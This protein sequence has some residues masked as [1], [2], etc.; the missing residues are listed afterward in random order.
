MWRRSVPDVLLP[1]VVLLVNLLATIFYIFVLKDKERLGKFFALPILLQKSF[2]VL[3]VG[4]LVVSPFVPQLKVDMSPVFTVP[5]GAVL[6][7]EGLL[8]IPFSF[9]KIGVVPS[10]RK[11]SGLL[12]SGPYGVVRHP[13]YS[14]TLSIVLGLAL[15][16]NALISLS[17]FPLLV[18]LYYLTTAY[19]EKDLVHAYPDEYPA[20][21]RRV[22][23]RII[24]FVL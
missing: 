11:A 21:Q 12:T 4:P 8:M 6:F 14:G 10:L 16:R 3:F 24:P 19:E 5:V 23:R 17:Y 9:L 20:Y 1:L 7:A 15:W 22:K 18:F 2:V 13:I